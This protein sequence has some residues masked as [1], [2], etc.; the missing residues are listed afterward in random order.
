MSRVATVLAVVIVLTGGCRRSSEEKPSTAVVAPRAADPLAANGLGLRTS[1]DADARVRAVFP[2]GVATEDARAAIGTAPA[3]PD[4]VALDPTSEWIG[5]IV[6]TGPLEL[7]TVRAALPGPLVGTGPGHFVKAQTREGAWEYV[8]DETARG[9]YVRVAVSVSLADID[10]AISAAALD[11]EIA[12]TRAFLQK[13]DPREPTAS[14]TRAQALARSAAAF[15]LRRQLHDDIDIGLAILA[16]KGTT[17]SARLV[18]D[19]A[20]SAG[21]RWGDGDYF[22]WVPTPSTDVGQ[23]IEMGGTSREAGYFMPE[24]VARSDG[25]A[26]VTDLEMSF[27]IARTWEPG[28]VFTVMTRAAK[29]LARRLGGTVVSVE[30]GAP[31]DEEAARIKLDAIV[32]AMTDAGIKPGSSLALQ[33]F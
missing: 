3:P 20:Y 9:P 18:W 25:S 10:E 2:H 31:F 22:H 30:T 15:K 23:G 8:E 17:F 1:A 24:W 13:L 12:W 32:K 14:I 26:D 33:V 6:P 7:A 11:R 5:E 28:A 4:D 19:A 21:F 27:N 29:Y 16:P